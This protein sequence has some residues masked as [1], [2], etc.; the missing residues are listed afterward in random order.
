MVCIDKY[1]EID[2]AE[3][4]VSFSG[5]SK[6]K[7]RWICEYQYAG[8]STFTASDFLEDTSHFKT[9]LVMVPAADNRDEVTFFLEAYDT[10]DVVHCR[11]SIKLTFSKFSI[12]PNQNSVEIMQGDTVKISTSTGR[13]S[14]TSFL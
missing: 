2:T 7:F 5:D 10:N 1:N 9:K 3:F 11:D 6:L 4:L 13:G 14:W 8:V 12:L